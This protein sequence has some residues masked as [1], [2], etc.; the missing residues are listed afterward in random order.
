MTY[1]FTGRLFPMALLG[2]AL[3]FTTAGMARSDEKEIR[4]YSDIEDAFIKKPDSS[5]LTL[6]PFLREESR[7]RSGELAY[8]QWNAG[9]R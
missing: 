5:P 3:W 7:F 1:R 8:Q 4:V 6:K 2:T 9:F